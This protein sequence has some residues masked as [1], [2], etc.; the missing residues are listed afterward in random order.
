MRVLASVGITL[1]ILLLGGIGSVSLAEE[2]V[3]S[4]QLEGQSDHSTQGTVSIRVTS[5]GRVLVLGADFE[6]DGAPDPKLGFGKD[7][8]QADSLFAKLERNY[9]FQTYKLPAEFDPAHHNEIWLWCE[10]FRVPLGVA[11]LTAE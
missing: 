1:C 5:T 8:F 2:P 3:H 9:G 7:G 4:G 6:F 11:R 10:K